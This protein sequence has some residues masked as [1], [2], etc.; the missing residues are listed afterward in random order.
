MKTTPNKPVEIITMASITFAYLAALYNFSDG[1]L[2][3]AA[4]FA[5]TCYIV[6]EFM[7]INKIIE[8]SNTTK[9]CLIGL[10]IFVILL[11]IARK[12]LPTV[13]AESL[14]SLIDDHFTGRQLVPL[15]FR[16]HF[17]QLPSEVYSLVPASPVV[18]VKPTWPGDGVWMHLGSTI[19]VFIHNNIRSV[20]LFLFLLVLAVTLVRVLTV[21]VADRVRVATVADTDVKS[22]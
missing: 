14:A 15:G 8:A 4:L 21:A 3:G 17:N 6:Y 22:E 13:F 9:C 12:F 11:S 16:G 5:L 2:I 1:Y 20:E 10:L 7:I 19:E 18:M